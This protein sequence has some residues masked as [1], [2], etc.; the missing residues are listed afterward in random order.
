M[1]I[2]LTVKGSCQKKQFRTY[3]HVKRKRDSEELSDDCYLDDMVNDSHD[4]Q[5]SP[6][7][8]N[9]QLHSPYTAMVIQTE[10]QHHIKTLSHPHQGIFC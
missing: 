7:H 3:R 1:T 2:F 9:T 8:S 4:H 6:Q 10:P 5:D